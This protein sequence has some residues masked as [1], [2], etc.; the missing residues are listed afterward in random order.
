MSEDITLLP[1]A[2]IALLALTRAVM[3]R[4]LDIDE[5][6]V[7]NRIHEANAVI[8]LRLSAPGYGEMLYA[9]RVITVLEVQG[10]RMTPLEFLELHADQLCADLEAEL[11]ESFP[12]RRRVRRSPQES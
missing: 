2:T 7:S 10:S 6:S 11:H 9:E 4:G 5:A 1:M 12:K 3:W 8:V